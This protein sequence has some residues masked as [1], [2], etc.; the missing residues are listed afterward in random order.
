MNVQ[1]IQKSKTHPISNQQNKSQKKKKKKKGG[2]LLSIFISLCVFTLP[3]H[4]LVLRLHPS[5]CFPSRIEVAYAPGSSPWFPP[6]SSLL[7]LLLLLYLSGAIAIAFLDSQISSSLSSLLFSSL[8]FSSLLFLKNL[9]FCVRDYFF[10]NF[11]YTVIC[12][13]IELAAEDCSRKE[14]KDN[15]RDEDEEE[16]RREKREEEEERRE[17]R[18]EERIL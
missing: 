15:G 1:E 17:K 13:L 2:A 8:L 4:R 7:L 5:G 11:H 3:F 14:R 12:T 6:P 9:L 18:E 10:G 16:E